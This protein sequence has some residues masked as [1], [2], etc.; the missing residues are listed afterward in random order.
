LTREREGGLCA[1]VL[2]IGLCRSYFVQKADT[3]VNDTT[4]D[5]YPDDFEEDEGGQRDSL[6]DA[7]QPSAEGDANELDDD[8]AEADPESLEARMAKLVK[9]VEAAE[10]TTDALKVDA[11][12]DEEAARLALAEETAALEELEVEQGRPVQ[13]G[14]AGGT[15]RGIDHQVDID[16]ALLRSPR[17][18]L[19]VCPLYRCPSPSSL[20]E[21]TLLTAVNHSTAH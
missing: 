19:R 12:D 13:D 6:Q 17:I 14:A 15:S 8:E 11:V 3:S 5:D 20:V 4:L 16:P 10:A 2:L 1:A 9:G 18:L 7:N 21:S